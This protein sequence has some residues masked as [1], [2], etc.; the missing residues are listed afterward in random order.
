ME[1]SD[2][3]NCLKSELYPLWLL[4][5]SFYPKKK[6][7]LLLSTYFIFNSLNY[8][9]TYFGERERE[10][11]RGNGKWS[12][13]FISPLLQMWEDSG[14]PVMSNSI[15][16]IILL[17]SSSFWCCMNLE[18]N[19]LHFRDVPKEERRGRSPYTLPLKFGS[20]KFWFQNQKVIELH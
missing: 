9:S 1:Y 14:R 17:C 3:K 2:N 16:V 18:L 4:L 13:I 20:E 15:R 19:S 5:L 6:R 8:I 11:E 7:L 10:R 12:T